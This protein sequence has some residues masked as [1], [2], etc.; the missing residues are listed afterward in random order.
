MIELNTRKLK[1]GKKIEKNVLYRIEESRTVPVREEHAECAESEAVYLDYILEDGQYA[2]FAHEF[3]SPNVLKHNCKSADILTCLIDD[4]DKEIISLIL[5]IKRNIS[6]FSDDLLR[7]GAILSAVGEVRDFVKQLCHAMLHKESFLLYLKNEGYAESAEVAIATKRFEKEKFLKAAEFLEGLA[8]LE[9]PPNM[10]PL[11][12]YKLK[13]DL[14]PYMGEAARMRNFA[15][16]EVIVCGNIYPLHVYLLERAGEGE[17]AVS[18]ELNF[19]Q[20]VHKQ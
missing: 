9:K 16:R 18:V 17:Y 20:K 5:D 11:V 7:D 12:W 19:S 1:P 3:R 14:L 13:N 6:A 8:D 2:V 10:Q 15:N 4:N